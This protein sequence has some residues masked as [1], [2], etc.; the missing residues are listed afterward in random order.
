L[1][2]TLQSLGRIGQDPQMANRIVQALIESTSG[3]AAPTRMPAAPPQPGPVSSQA[4]L[5]SPEDLPYLDRLF[6][7]QEMPFDIGGT[8]KPLGKAARRLAKKIPRGATTTI[9]SFGRD[10]AVGT[11]VPFEG[12]HGTFKGGVP[13]KA[14]KSFGGLHAGTPDAARMR[15]EYIRPSSHRQGRPGGQQF[16]PI[17]ATSKKSYGTPEN[18]ISETELASINAF[19]DEIQRLKNDGFDAIFYRNTVEDP[20]S[21]SIQIL[22]TGII[23]PR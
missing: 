16:F 20:G 15:V 7:G 18:P 17:N 4:Q 11:N 14:P 1:A 3:G 12:V 23:N 5:M 8:A 10:V 21:V 2:G 13:D 9:S 22:D 6:R 19:P